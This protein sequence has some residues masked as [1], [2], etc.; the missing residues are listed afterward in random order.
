[1]KAM[2]KEAD[3][4]TLCGLFGKSRQAYYERQKS[5][6]KEAMEEDLLVNWVLIQRKSIGRVG[7]KKL[8]HLLQISVE[9]SHIKVGRDGFFGVL[10]GHGL[11]INRRR[12]YALTTNSH[13]WLKK[14]KNIIKDMEINESERLWVSDITYLSTL[15]GFCYLSL[16]TDAYSRKIMGYQVAQN[17][18]TKHGQSIVHVLPP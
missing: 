1:M 4:G 18:E 11:L 15:E 6:E 8:Y 2:Y 3:L 12:K 13:H 9:M 7:G 17:L 5:V 14:Y 16:I 10:Q